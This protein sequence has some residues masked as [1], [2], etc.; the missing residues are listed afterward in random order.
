MIRTDFN[1]LRKGYRKLSFYIGNFLMYA[2]PNPIYR[3]FFFESMKRLSKEEKAIAHERAQYYVRIP[4][5]ASIGENSGVQVC[6]FTYPFGK[7]HKFSAYFF[8]LYKYVRLFKAQQHFCYL[9]GD[10]DYETTEPTFVKSRPITK[11]ATHS[12]LCKLDR[13]RHFAFVND[14]NTFQSKQ[15]KLVFRNVVKKQ[16][17]RTR[18]IEMYLDHPMCDIGRVNDNVDDG[19]PEYV[20]PYMSINDQLK[21][22]FICCIEGHDVA[23]NLK[24][25]MSSN[26]LAVTPR[27]K[28]ESWFM[29]GQLIGNYHYVEIKD[30][31][32]DLIEK[33]TYYIEHPDEAEAIIAHAHEYVQRFLNP[34]LEH[35]TSYLV[36]QQ[37]FEQTEKEKSFI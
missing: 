3:F 14:S 23:T 9:F 21:Y 17:H 35:Y 34:R 28:I 24:W 32:S 16:P 7:K 11:G 29:E 18:F 22:K 25:A 1:S 36:L 30:D 2:I 4:Q 13:I 5:G 26:S 15:N 6:E 27:P 37:Y 10:I 8:D 20:K 33:L 19:H 31:Y 12:V